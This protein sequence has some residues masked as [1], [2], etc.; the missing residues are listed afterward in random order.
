MTTHTDLIN[1][2]SKKI[3]AESYLEIGVYNAALNF[4]KITV[5]L[6]IGID[7]DPKAKAI[8]RLTSDAYFKTFDRKYDIIFIDGLHYSSQCERDLL[9]AWRCLTEK[10]IIIMHDCNPPTE[11]TTCLPRGE[12]GEWCGDV[13]KTACKITSPKFTVDFDYGCC[14]INKSPVLR[15]REWDVTWEEFDKSRSSLLNLVSVDKFIEQW[16]H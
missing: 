14:V 2:I 6:K 8:I 7:P 10:G 15:L 13:Y 12:Q 4:D 1:Y 9:N 3:V 16:L 11:E 5:P